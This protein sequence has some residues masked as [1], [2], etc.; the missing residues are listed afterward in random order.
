MTS[1]TPGM[2]PREMRSESRCFVVHSRPVDP[3]HLGLTGRGHRS[4]ARKR[5]CKQRTLIL[6]ALQVSVERRDNGV[7]SGNVARRSGRITTGHTRSLR[8]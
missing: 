7:F 5:L 1:Q 2:S 4:T 3:V 6:E 8:A